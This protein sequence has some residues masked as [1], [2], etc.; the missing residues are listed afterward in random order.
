MN[1]G[2]ILSI[3]IATVSYHQINISQHTN[4]IWSFEPDPRVG[5]RA[6]GWIKVPV[7]E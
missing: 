5:S 3:K 1:K 2:S 6:Y 7:A 4:R